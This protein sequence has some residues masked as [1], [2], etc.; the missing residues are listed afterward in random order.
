MLELRAMASISP[1]SVDRPAPASSSRDGFAM[2]LSTVVIFAL[3]SGLAY[4]RQGVSAGME[5]SNPLN[6]RYL[7]LP[8]L[9]IAGYSLFWPN[10]AQMWR[11]LPLRFSLA[12]LAMFFYL[13]VSILWTPEGDLRAMSYNAEFFL[14]CMVFM[15]VLGGVGDTG[16]I[17]RMVRWL[18]VVTSIAY[19]AIFL[20]PAM[21]PAFRGS[22]RVAGLWVNPNAA[23]TMLASMLPLIVF[24]V[25]PW[26]RFALYALTFVGVLVTL[27]RGGLVIWGVL[28]LVTLLMPPGRVTTTRRSEQVA[29]AG[30]ALLVSVL[31]AAA[32]TQNFIGWMTKYAPVAGRITSRHDF[33][34][35]ERSLVLVLGWERFLERPIFGWGAGSTFDWGYR[36][37]T[38][39]MIVLMAAE[40]GLV[41]LSLS[42]IW[43]FTLLGF[44]ATFGIYAFVYFA[45]A[46][47]FSHNMFQAEQAVIV[48]LYWL[49]GTQYVNRFANRDAAL[50]E[51]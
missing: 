24:G 8:L 38:H 30:G 51:G 2:L 29:Y 18:A 12:S 34:V 50:A 35:A 46:G 15:L 20:F 22:G 40:H 36:A 32:A 4:F 17:L 31:G 27:S 45:T 44:G 47:M 10:A 23:A 42:A 14:M 9:L 39:N 16:R 1:P 28:F 37:S 6:P 11:G 41:G 48:A 25:A 13:P 19:I 21:F 26:T 43:M 5:I 3:Y 7:H 33:S 49:A